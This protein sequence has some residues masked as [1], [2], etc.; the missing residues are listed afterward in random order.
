MPFVVIDDSWYGGGG[1]M[2]KLQESLRGFLEVEGVRT[3]A[4]I[5]IATGLIVRSVGKPDPEL[6][7]TAACVADEA[8]AV[9]DALGTVG[10]LGEDDAPDD[11]AD[12]VEISTVTGSRLQVSRIL[13]SRPGDGLLLF[14]DL[15]RNRSNLGLA[16]LRVGQL[17]SA[18]LA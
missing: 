15:E 3:A 12:V 5:D 14:I 10:A 9:R 6:P 8:R 16:T 11:Q 2:S 7:V 1:A 13:R 4:V 17:A 18:V